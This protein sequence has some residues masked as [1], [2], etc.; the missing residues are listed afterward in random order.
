MTTFASIIDDLGGGAAVARAIGEEPGTVRQWKGR[1]SIPADR[2]P[3]IVRL[4]GEKG[5]DAITY[6]HLAK[7][8]KPRK[9]PRKRPAP[10]RKRAAA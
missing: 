9:T 2:W 4:A 10:K 1:N 6:E 8:A 7:L 3:R 5:E